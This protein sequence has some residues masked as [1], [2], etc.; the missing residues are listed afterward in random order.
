VRLGVR[1]DHPVEDLAPFVL[2]AIPKRD[3]AALDQTLE[4]AADA[5][6]VVLTEGVQHAMALF[7]ERV[8]PVNET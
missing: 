1:P 8:K 2:S 3:R 7:N 6:E 5:I 4:R